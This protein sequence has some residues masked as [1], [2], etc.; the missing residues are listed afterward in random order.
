[1]SVAGKIQSGVL[2][3]PLTTFKIGGPAKYFVEAASAAELVEAINWAKKNQ[4]KYFILGG[5]SNL[6]I[7][8][9]GYNG[10]VIKNKSRELALDGETISCDSGLPLAALLAE[11]SRRGL[12]GLEWAAGIPGTVGGAIRGNAGAHG[13]S[14]SLNLEQANVYQPGENKIETF[15]NEQCKFTYRHSIFKDSNLLV[16]GGTFKLKTG[17]EQTIRQTVK[18]YLALRAGQPN[19]PSAG[20]VF[21]NIFLEQLKTDNG[22]KFITKAENDKVIKGDKVSTGWLISTLGLRGKK[23]GGA[24]I[25]LD[26]AN[27]II[28]TGEATA[29]DVITLMSLIKQKIRVE[30]GIQLASEIE[31]LDY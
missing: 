28:N 7:S 10:L 21:K 17:Q 19:S 3:A 5:G 26:H 31:Y 14:I 4:E 15:T 13:A 9:W 2:L 20:C 8:D 11:A 29:A 18:E 24:K 22:R 12:S 27:F 25:S 16:L 23:I 6:L 1:M 30:A